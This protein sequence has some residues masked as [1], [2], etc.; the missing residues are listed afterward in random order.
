MCV[1]KQVEQKMYHRA[2]SEPLC[3]SPSREDLTIMDALNLGDKLE[4]FMLHT[5]CQA[6][7]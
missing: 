1:G 6:H 4:S 3:L 2:I 7:E 5:F